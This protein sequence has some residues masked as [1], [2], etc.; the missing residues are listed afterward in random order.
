MCQQ[1]TFKRFRGKKGY[2]TRHSQCRM[3]S[4]AWNLHAMEIH[5][6]F[7][8]IW[9]GRVRCQ[10]LL[11]M[12]TFTCK[13]CNVFSLFSLSF[14]LLFDVGV[15]VSFTLIFQGVC[16]LHFRIHST[17]GL[18]PGG[19]Y[20]DWMSEQKLDKSWRQTTTTT[21]T[22]NNHQTLLF[23]LLTFCLSLA[24]APKRMHVWHLWPCLTF[25]ARFL[26]WIC[27]L[28]ACT[29]CMFDSLVDNFNHAEAF[30]FHLV[31]YRNRSFSL[32]LSR[33]SIVSTLL[34]FVCVMVDV[35][36]LWCDFDLFD[37]YTVWLYRGSKR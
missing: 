15:F 1:I 9:T 34:F 7:F 16:I 3:H 31:L 19:L 4:A 17:I 33:Q 5:L 21:T 37:S 30:D 10:Q 36:F 26:Q 18:A 6:L 2:P 35:L 29:V 32:S 23:W 13:F 12:Y 14:S 24:V 8:L 22:T 28:Y 11:Q 25:F 20:L 27:H